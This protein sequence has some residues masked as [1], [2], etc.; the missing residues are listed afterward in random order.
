MKAPSSSPRFLNL[1]ALC[2]GLFLG[3]IVL[4]IGLRVVPPFERRIRGNTIVLPAHRQYHYSSGTLR[5]VDKTIIHTKNNLGFRG[6]ELPADGLSRY[7]SIIAVGGST[8]ECTYLSDGKDWPALLADSLRTCFDSVWVN[9]AGLDGHST[10]GH[11]LLLNDC[12]FKLQPRVILFLVG[13]C[14]IG[15]SDTG[16]H[17]AAQIKGSI[18]FNSVEGMVKSVAAYSEIASLALDA[19]RYCRAAL[20]GLPHYSVNLLPLYGVDSNNS[21][22]DL[23]AYRTKLI[24][25][26]EQR[27][28]ALIDLAKSNGIVPVVITQP[29]YSGSKQAESPVTILSL[30]NSATLRVGAAAQVPTIDLAH[31]L[32]ENPDYFYDGIHFTNLGARAVAAA[33][34]QP[35]RLYFGNASTSFCKDTSDFAGTVKGLAP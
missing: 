31:L 35:L 13:I 33:L 28:T 16:E 6:P 1:I 18:R 26:Y 34:Y 17:A 19:Y 20:R 8:T 3:A 5:G 25:A 9:N 29:S 32:A 2:I 24:P 27:L 7:L 14:D 11:T 15:R 23:I 12:I 30:Y 10:Y 4:E 21:G 22:D